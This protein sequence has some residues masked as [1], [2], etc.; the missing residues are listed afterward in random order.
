MR[1]GRGG[2]GRRG[3]DE[4]SMYGASNGGL[5]PGLISRPLNREQRACNLGRAAAAFS[6][7]AAFQKACDVGQIERAVRAVSSVR[8]RND[9]ALFEVAQATWREICSRAV[10]GFCI[11]RLSR[12]LMRGV[13][14]AATAPGQ[15]T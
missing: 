15:K 5:A 12:P 4:L 2:K 13:G 7:V 8:G 1:E 14:E 10:Y 3:V 9:A 6:I 11:K